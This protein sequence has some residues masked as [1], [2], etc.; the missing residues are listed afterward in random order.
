M[1]KIIESSESSMI[2]TR[3]AIRTAALLG[4][5][6]IGA[7]MM[8]HNFKVFG[9]P[10]KAKKAWLMS[11]T[12]FVVVFG[13]GYVMKTGDETGGKHFP[14]YLLLLIYSALISLVARDYQGAEIERHINHGGPTYGALRITGL[15]ALG[16]A[17]MILPWSLFI[18]LLGNGSPL[19][20]PF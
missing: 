6:F 3:N 9:T 7:Y 17:A 5:P 2:Y 18:I 11:I 4:G 14:T 8:D 15:I 19:H 13:F 1:D 12:V 10:E 20:F 16:L